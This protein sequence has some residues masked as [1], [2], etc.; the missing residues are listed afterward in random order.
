M[1]CLWY[2]VQVMPPNK[3]IEPTPPLYLSDAVARC[4]E[5]KAAGHAYKILEAV[6]PNREISEKVLISRTEGELA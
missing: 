6:P 4:E 5:L 3:S 2:L 1:A